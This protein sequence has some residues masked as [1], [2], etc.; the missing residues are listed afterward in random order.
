MKAVFFSDAHIRDHRDPNLPP[1]LDFLDSLPG[2]L[3]RLYVVG[4]L[5]DTWFAFPRTVYAVYVPLLGAL[6]RV[7]RRGAR[8]IY[9]AGN[10]D[11][12]MGPFFTEVL[13]AEVHQAGVVI[14]E[15]G[16]RAYVAHGDLANPADRKYRL[17]RRTLRAAPT[18]WLARHLPPAWVWHIAQSMTHRF[19]GE[20]IA[21]RMPLKE[22]F[23]EFAARKLDE[24]FDTVI[25]GHSH[26]PAF[27]ARAGK[28]YVNLGDWVAAR[29]YLEWTDGRL[30]LK[31]WTR[32]GKE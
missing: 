22:V 13:E 8:I 1:L 30:A 15:D 5:F 26:L 31:S 7:R 25:L 18:R 24:G 21:R 23:A 3:D 2:T 10:H 32:T 4:D 16:L 9:L 19:T 11:F 28:T 6:H 27:D 14:E 17:L 20:E 29:T 12:E